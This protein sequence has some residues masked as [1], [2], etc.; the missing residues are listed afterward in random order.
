MPKSKPP[1]VPSPLRLTLKKL[2]DE[3][4]RKSEK[5]EDA[6]VEAYM[7]KGRILRDLMA[8]APSADEETNRIM[9]LRIG[10]AS[11]DYKEAE[12]A[13]NERAPRR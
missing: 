8:Y 10:V 13:M 3:A 2:I 1:P 4:E 12:R 6:L 9:R 5:K 11:R 7:R